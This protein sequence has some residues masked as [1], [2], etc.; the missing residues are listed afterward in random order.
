MAVSE[1]IEIVRRA[2]D[3]V[4]RGDHAVAA[5]CFGPDAEWHNTASFPGPAVIVGVRAIIEFHAELSA[6][7][8]AEGEQ[9]EEVRAVGDR[10]AMAVRTRASGKSSGVPVDVRW[11]LVYTLLDERVERV[12]V[13]GDFDRACEVAELLE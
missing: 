2:F 3:A 7:M 13:H 8:D 9:V 6:T 11:A 4:R 12:D 10:V 1:S 5:S